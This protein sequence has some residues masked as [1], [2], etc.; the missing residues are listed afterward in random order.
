MTASQSGVFDELSCVVAQAQSVG[1]TRLDECQREG[2]WVGYVERT[3][4]WW[5]IRSK[6]E[7]KYFQKEDGPPRVMWEV[8]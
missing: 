3:T 1:V 6:E 7:E 2:C 4:V 8:R 5:H